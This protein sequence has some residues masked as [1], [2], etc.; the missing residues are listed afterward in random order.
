MYIYI[1]IYLCFHRPLAPYIKICIQ[2]GRWSPSK[3]IGFFFC[4]LIAKKKAPQAATQMC[5][6]KMRRA[7]ESSQTI[8]SQHM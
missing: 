8:A 7:D 2:T 1:F 3:N 6:G 5:P 4:L